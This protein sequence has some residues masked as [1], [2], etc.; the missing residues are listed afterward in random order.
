MKIL[1]NSAK[2]MN[3]KNESSKTRNLPLKSE[4][5]LGA[6]LKLSLQDI[7]K[8]FKIKE[9][10]AK[11]EK[12]NFEKIQKG[13][14]ET[15][16]AIN[17]FDGL[18]YRNIDR[19]FTE[20]DIE[21]IKENVFITTSFYGIINALEK[22]SEHRLDFLQNIKIEGKSLRKLWQE[23]YDVFAKDEDKILSLLSSEFEEVFSKEI[24]KK[25]IRIKFIEE[26]D[27]VHKVHSTISKKARGKFVSLLIRNKI[28]NFDEVKKITFDN[29]KFEEKLSTD[30]E[31]VFVDK[32]GG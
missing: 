4:K 14:S 24:R 26:K 18:M 22:I 10:R 12:N 3:T 17:L 19:D 28:N 15:Y 11:V 16:P 9:D 23:D 13:V 27:G 25:F 7:A 1:I 8:V 32:I 21:Y 20:Q 29:Y 5:I 31:Y 6:I 30:R 2:E